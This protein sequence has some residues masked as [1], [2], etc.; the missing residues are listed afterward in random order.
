MTSDPSIH[1]NQFE[2]LGG[3]PGMVAADSR[4][5]GRLLARL[6]LAVGRIDPL[7]H[8]LILARTPRSHPRR[9]MD[10]LDRSTPDLPRRRPMSVDQH[11]RTR[12]TPPRTDRS[13]LAR[14]LV[15]PGLR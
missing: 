3:M 8:G 7:S 12:R 1:H 15:T 14:L 9:R 2:K 5:A 4:A 6:L 11:V 10:R 13:T